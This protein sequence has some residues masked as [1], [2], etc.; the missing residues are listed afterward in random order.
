[1]VQSY[2]LHHSIKIIN[3]DNN[4]FSLIKHPRTDSPLQLF[5]RNVKSKT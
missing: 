5:I 3:I 4:I 2:F 1:M